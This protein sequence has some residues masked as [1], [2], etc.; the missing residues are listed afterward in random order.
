MTATKD[1]SLDRHE[2]N[3]QL[4]DGIERPPT[5]VV[6]QVLQQERR[7]QIL[8]VIHDAGEAR[9]QKEVLAVLK[10]KYISHVS[11]HFKMMQEAGVLVL[12]DMRH[13]RTGGGPE[14]FYE[15]AVK[16]DPVVMQYLEVIQD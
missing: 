1:A 2:P 10:K 16:T 5:D 14:R 4:P 11:H 3:R 12:T 9:S 8:R 15:S 13:G 7:R 6:L